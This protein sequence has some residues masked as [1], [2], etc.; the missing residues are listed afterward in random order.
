MDDTKLTSESMS[1][2]IIGDIA[3]N[4]ETLKRLH[5]KMPEG[6]LISVGDM[7]DRGSNSKGVLDYIRKHG[8]AILGNHEHL[9]IDAWEGGD[10]Y[11]Y[12][13]WFSNGGCYTL[14]SFTDVK[15]D[16]DFA[17]ELLDDIRSQWQSFKTDYDF[18][19]LTGARIKA[20]CQK[21]IPKD[22]ID[23]MK[24]LP[25]YLEFEGLIITHAPIN[26]TLEFEEIL[27]L[28]Q[29]AGDRECDRSVIWH[30]EGVKRIEDKFQVHG[31][32]SY[33]SPRWFKDLEGDFAV[34]VDAC[35]GDFLTGI[36]WPSKEIYTDIYMEPPRVLGKV[37]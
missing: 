19:N 18:V 25:L 20:L 35:K 24:S 31:H 17:F 28:G 12:G 11:D 27:N 10:Y 14:A 29:H 16:Q 36:H 6:Q 21:V 9:M 5:E 22:Y 23:W 7:V 8:K 3:G 26:P 33:R 34:C 13:V 15:K 30:R 4:L 2:N 32:N 1:L 37:I